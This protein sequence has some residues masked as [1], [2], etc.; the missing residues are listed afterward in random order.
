[1]TE[2]AWLATPLFVVARLQIRLVHNHEIRV[3]MRSTLTVVI[4]L[5]AMSVAA[6]RAEPPKLAV[7]DLE[8]I[9]TSLQGEVDGPRTD[10]QARPLRTG[11]QARRE[12]ADS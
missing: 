3:C 5:L 1:M 7:F 8:M 10:E 2:L 4:S 11:D 12:L 9:D 6:A